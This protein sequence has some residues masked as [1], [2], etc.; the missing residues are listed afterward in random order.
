MK[1]TNNLGLPQP[2]VEAV[3]REYTYKDK[4]YS[5]TALLKGVCQTMLER[6]YDNVI[7]QDVSDMIWLIFG[8]S[9]HSILE[10]AE[11]TETQLKENKLIIDVNGYKLSGIF[12]L[13]DEA[14]KTVTDYKTATVWKV[15]NNDW[16][17]YRKQLLMY[18]WM[19]K[20]IGF[21]CENGEIVALLKDHS[22]TK[23]KIDSS[24][25]PYPVHKV[26]FHFT[27]KDFKEIEEFVFA[28]FEEIKKA[29]QLSDD[30]LTPCTQEERWQEPTKYAV[31]KKGNK[32]ALKIHDS[33]ELANKHCES[34]E[35]LEIEVRPSIPKKCVD[36]CN[37]NG[38]CKFYQTYLKEKGE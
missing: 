35:G 22:K 37:V 10:N 4:Q 7:E 2:F 12:D 23:A 27:D 6:R 11:E 9:V 38:F 24:Y 13:Y 5:V 33:L 36:Y 14:T 1:I 3:T 17:D 32:R 34:A 8:T 16:E 18:A 28:K 15:I 30:E 19:L 25:P 21:E 31:K 29:E 20:Q 26:M